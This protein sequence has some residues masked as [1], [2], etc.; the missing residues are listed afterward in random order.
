MAS[1]T[2]TRA[3]DRDV[4]RIALPATPRKRPRQARSIVLVDALKKAGAG[5]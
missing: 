1:A 3:A 2:R 5:S 4:L